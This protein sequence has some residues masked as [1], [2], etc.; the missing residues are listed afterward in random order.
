MMFALMKIIFL[1]LCIL[2]YWPGHSQGRPPWESPLKMAWSNDGTTF[3]NTTIF[4]D[5]SGVP[6]VIKWKGD[7]LVCAFQWFRK[8]VN[9][10]SWD[11]VGVKFSYNAGATWTQP[12]PITVAGI[13]TTYQRPFDPTLAVVSGTSL[14]IYFSSSQLPVA[15]LDATVNTYSAISN[16]GVNYTF[17]PDPRFDHPTKQVIDPAV[18][19]FNGSWHYAAPAGAPQDGAFHCISSNGINFVQ[20]SNYPSDMSHNW[21]G[22]FMINNPGELRF[23]GSGPQVWFNTSMDGNTWQGF[24]N[25]NIRGGDPSVVKIATANYLAIFVGEPYITGLEEQPA[26]PDQMTIYPNPVSDNI[27]VKADPLAD[28]GYRIYSM[29][30]NIE[31]SG[32]RSGD[33]TI[34]TI[35]LSKGIY[36]LLIESGKTTKAFKFIK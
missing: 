1:L 8:P 5:S 35:E 10:T 13:P 25:T 7:T 15:G 6:S 4:Q 17:E 36:I 29:L 33:Q 34:S 16:N 12:V 20:Q 28:Y 2:V 18:I 19:Y 11:K 31:L 9:S 21:T 30:G 26:E 23:Y 14:R 22:N 27:A 24:A 3:T 32:N